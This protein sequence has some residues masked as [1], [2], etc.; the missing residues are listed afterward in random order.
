MKVVTKIRIVGLE[1]KE[2]RA[3]EVMIA[4]KIRL[5]E[6]A[7]KEKKKKLGI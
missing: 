1:G 3:N 5:L 7:K 2:S 6:I 4:S